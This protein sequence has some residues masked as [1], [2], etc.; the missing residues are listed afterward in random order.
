MPIYNPGAGGGDPTFKG[1]FL[2]PAT[3]PP[4]GQFGDYA[5]V[6]ST[7][8]F[9]SWD[10]TGGPGWVDT[11][12]PAS[13][14]SHNTLLGLQG[15]Q[16]GEYYHLKLAEHVAMQ[17]LVGGGD[18]SGLHQH[19]WADV[20]KAG[21][22]IAHL[23]TR[24]HSDLTEIGTNTHAAIDTHITTPFPHA[25][26]LAQLNNS[27]T[28]ATLGDIYIDFNDQADN[29]ELVLADAF[30]MIRMNKA[31]SVYLYIP[32]NSAV[33]FPIGTQILA[34]MEGAGQVL[35]VGNSGV[36]VRGIDRISTQY[37]GAA[38]VKDYTD[39]WTVYG[40]SA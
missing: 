29:Y 16:G 21:S 10:I 33:P 32:A 18:A 34:K 31:T 17:T 15:G 35:F 14:W 2:T 7:S 11:G 40:S 28:D 3:L 30:K 5:V 23:A 24:K 27:V 1:Y 26:T 12:T 36:T 38:L 22:S 9:W 37:R 4:T 6:S 19:A 20:L 25:G 13:A 39:E 8:T